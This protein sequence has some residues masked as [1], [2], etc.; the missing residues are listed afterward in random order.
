[1]KARASGLCM[2]ARIRRSVSACPL[3][4]Q[5]SYDLICRVDADAEN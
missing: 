5:Y 1:M 4:A 3:T 2:L